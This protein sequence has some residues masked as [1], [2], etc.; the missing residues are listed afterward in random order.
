[1]NLISRPV[2]IVLLVAGLIVVGV[3]GAYAY[4]TRVKGLAT[5]QYYSFSISPKEATVDPGEKV[6]VTLKGDDLGDPIE[7]PDDD[8]REGV[9]DLAPADVASTKWCTDLETNQWTAPPGSWS[10]NVWATNDA[11]GETINVRFVLFSDWRSPGYVEDTAITLHVN[12]LPK[13]TYDLTTQVSPPDGGSINPFEGTRTYE[14]GQKV[15]LTAMPSPGYDFESWSGDI[16][17]NS[18]EITV[19]MNSDMTLTANFTKEPTPTVYTL[20]TS[21][22]PLGS[23]YIEPSSGRYQAGEEVT[24]TAIAAQGYGFSNWTGDASGTSKEVTITMNSDKSVTANFYKKEPEPVEYTLTTE[25]ARG[26][27][28]ITPSGGKYEKGETVTLKAEPDEGYDFHSWSGD[29]SGSENPKAV[30]MNA[31]KHIVAS[32]DRVGPEMVTLHM[33]ANPTVG[34][35]VQI[36]GE[37][38]PKGPAAFKKGTTV[39]VKA[40]PNRGYKFTHW[41]GDASGRE[42]SISVLMNSDKSIT[43]NFEEAKTLMEQA[44]E[45][46]DLL[47]IGIGS[48]TSLVGLIG[49]FTRWL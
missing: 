15:S 44:K 10:C 14:E 12:E 29:I 40:R 13:P 16:S 43:A 39:T 48:V 27:G 31:D 7:N 21:V 28:S 35:S 37:V 32:F 38:L 24:L 8:L 25:V 20:T 45:N 46:A 26:Q 41:S 5:K 42:K 4:R 36:T 18:K 19:T 11:A 22:E 23:G 17:S 1:M 9:N 34:G 6:R 3:S 47:G 33:H 49:G 2:G 30:T